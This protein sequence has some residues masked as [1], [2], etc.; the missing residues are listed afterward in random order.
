[1]PSPTLQKID[2]WLIRNSSVPLTEKMF[3]TEN[4]RVMVHAGLSLSEAL[5]TLALQSESKTFRT[6]L[7]EVREGVVQGRLLSVELAKFPKAFPEIFIKMIEVGEISGTLEETLKE[8]TNQIKK[9]YTLRSKVKGA[10]TYPIVILVAM[11]GITIAL[12]VFVLP[13]LLAIFKE[14]GDVKLPL[15]TRILIFASDFTQQNGLLVGVGALALAGA[16]V[17][18]GRTRAGRSLFHLM[19]IRSPLIGP[20][21]RK[22]NLARFSRT[23]SSLLRTDVPVV[24]SL[25]ITAAVL[26]NV[27]YRTSVEQASERIKKGDNI[28]DTLKEYPKLYP[29]LVVQMTLVG[30]RSGNIDGLLA[31]VA[32]FYEEQVDQTLANLSSIIEPILILIL[33]GMVGG[34][35]LAVMTP[36]YALTQSIAES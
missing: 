16:V 12:L 15:P 32:D 18:F 30:E 22:V 28:S 7:T 35:A 5:S 27:H 14:F 1:M 31:D 20:V 10:M 4:L 2:Q 36:M 13:K 29:P 26:G 9:D 21:A 25:T 17:A 33:G 3:F 19:V 11:L 34:I 24:Q 23:F 8:L 6:I